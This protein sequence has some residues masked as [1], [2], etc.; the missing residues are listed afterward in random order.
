MVAHK[1]RD[2]AI[3][4]VCL[5]TQMVLCAGTTKSIKPDHL[6]PSLTFLEGGVMVWLDKLGV[7]HSMA[8]KKVLLLKLVG[9]AACERSRNCNILRVRTLVAEAGRHGLECAD[10]IN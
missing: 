3:W 6:S 7:E 9:H 1:T 5:L 8:T 10:E 4:L 2:I